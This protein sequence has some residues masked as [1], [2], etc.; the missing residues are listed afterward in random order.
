MNSEFD[1]FNQLRRLLAL[2][3]HEQPPPGYFDRFSSQVISRIRAGERGE[4]DSVLDRMFAGVAWFWRLRAALE[5][6]PAFA[7]AMGAAVCALMITG[8]MYSESGG[9]AQVPPVIAGA[10]I[11]SF[12][13]TVPLAV[14]NALEQVRL[15][16]S[17]NP[18]APLASSLF[19]QVQFPPIERAAF[20]VPGGN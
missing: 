2:K 19:D 20:I 5:A 13:N 8:I 12:G 16:S 1:S 14:D 17:T 7:G 15:A 4:P 9:S 11:S 18:V 6:R 10:G 3:R